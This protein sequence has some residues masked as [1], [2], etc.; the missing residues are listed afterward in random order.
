MI[1]EKVR[2]R[3]KCDMSEERK[4]LHSLKTIRRKDKTPITQIS[5]AIF[6]RDFK[7]NE[8]DE[9]RERFSIDV[10]NSKAHENKLKEILKEGRKDRNGAY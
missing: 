5:G 8:L 7:I 1:D 6:N 3:E 9:K 4:K 10:F 2:L